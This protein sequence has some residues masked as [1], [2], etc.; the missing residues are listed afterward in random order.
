MKLTNRNI[1]RDVA[2]FYVGLILAF[3][4]SG[5]IL[6]HRQSW[7]PQEYTYESM[8]V[9]LDIPDTELT[10]DV[11]QQMVASF[12][13]EYESFRVRENN[14][15]IDFRGNT[16]IEANMETGQG[17]LESRRTVPFLGHTITLHKTTDSAWI[18]YSDI[19]GAAMI[20]IA[21]T[22]MLISTG[23]NGFKNRGWK[24][25][26]AGLIFPLIFLFLI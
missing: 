16:M 5:I 10:D 22:G 8:E 23:K 26:V 25:M 17:V 12:G 21:I 15:R 7:Y 19:F 4:F 2:Y 6:N 3:A 13:H 1:H 20:L 14:L 9:N 24:L 11:V 18:W